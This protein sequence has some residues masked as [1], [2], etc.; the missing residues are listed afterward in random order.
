M[1]ILKEQLDN[2][3]VA[4][5][6]HVR[7]LGEN[8]Q[9]KVLFKTNKSLA[10]NKSKENYL[11]VFAPYKTLFVGDIIV[12]ESGNK[13]LLINDNTNENTTY[14]KFYCMEC[15]QEVKIMVKDIGDNNETKQETFYVNAD[16]ISSSIKIGADII[17]TSSKNHFT[18]QLNDISRHIKIND[19]F[20][21]GSKWCKW[22]IVSINYLN[23]LCEIYCEA[24]LSD[25]TFDDV[26]NLIAER[27]RY[28]TKPSTYV[29]SILENELNV[30][31]GGV[32]IP[33]L[34]VEKDGTPYEP[35]KPFLYE[36]NNNNV[37]INTDTNEI[38]GVNLGNTIVNISYSENE[39]DIV[40]GDKVTVNITETPPDI[41][42]LSSNIEE[43]SMII[44][45]TKQL[46]ITAT[47]NGD[48]YTMLNPISWTNSD[49]SV[50]TI[51]EDNLVIGH[52]VG[53]TTLIGVY[54]EKDKDNCTQVEINV[55][56]EEKPKDVFK[57]DIIDTDMKLNIGDT[58]ELA[59][60][61]YKNDVEIIPTPTLEWSIADN[62]ICSITDNTVSALVIGESNI[63]ASYQEQDDNIVI[64]D[65]IKITV[66][67]VKVEIYGVMTHIVPTSSVQVSGSKT[68]FSF[69]GLTSINGYNVYNPPYEVGEK[70]PT[71]L[72][73]MKTSPEYNTYAVIENYEPDAT[74][75]NNLPFDD[76]F[77]DETCYKL[78]Q[79]RDPVTITF[80][81]AGVTN[82]E[83]I[84]DLSTPTMRIDSPNDLAEYLTYTIDNEKGEITVQCILVFS[85]E[86]IYVDVYEKTSDT[87]TTYPLHLAS[88]F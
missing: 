85:Y 82:P 49:S 88:A 2:T 75:T 4:R 22:K 79:G 59:V 13:Y 71:P 70:P 34:S 18:F 55:T 33:T 53:T 56:I 41:Y 25:E 38:K 69:A 27:W 16:A 74:I 11:T 8:E 6:V 3:L 63:I 1:N 62:T 76:S 26:E 72:A 73:V 65:T 19:T 77:N 57:V 52:T 45:D 14:D 48:S 80:S 58:K 78:K 67:E 47:K 12:L 60:K 83:W 66:E 61:V 10:S 46:T 23:N 28:E 39:Q 51:N 43:I 64:S 84:I 40:K 54:K 37:S 44:N 24:T 36:T 86:P 5:G 32:M 87:Y 21:S 29:T 81:K 15:N 30:I 35:I 9:Y 20:F 7:K 42:V 50:A 68:K 17:T 31:E